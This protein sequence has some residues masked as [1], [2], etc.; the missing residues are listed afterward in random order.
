MKAITAVM[1][2][3]EQ[4][5]VVAGTPETAPLWDPGSDLTTKQRLQ[6]QTLEH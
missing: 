3:R 1:D 2:G 6:D 5:V 4:M